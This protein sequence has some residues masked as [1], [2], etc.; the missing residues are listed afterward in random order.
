MIEYLGKG[1]LL[2]LAAGFAPGPLLVLVISETLRHSIKDGIKV[3]AAPLLTDVPILLISLFI[4]AKLSAM[5]VLL[6]VISMCGGLFIL[7]LGYEGLRLKGVHIEGTEAGSNSLRKGILTNA[8][9]PHPY[10][11]YMTVGGPIFLRAL[12]QGMVSAASFFCSFLLFL[13]GSKVGLALLT[14]RSRSFLR[15]PV[16]LWIMRGL[17]LCLI[18]FSLTLLREGLKL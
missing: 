3:S 5:K 17:G 9:N 12:D 6:G 15:G 10:V 13:V 18:L 11:F 7:Y 16:Y 8:L 1:T 14:E 4:L 2:G